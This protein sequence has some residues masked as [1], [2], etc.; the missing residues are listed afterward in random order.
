MRSL[1]ASFNCAEDGI[2]IHNSQDHL[3][4]CT[5]IKDFNEKANRLLLFLSKLRHD[6][7]NYF[8]EK[9]PHCKWKFVVG[10]LHYY[11]TVYL[12]CIFSYIWISHCWILVC[13]FLVTEN[14]CLAHCLRGTL[15]KAYFKVLYKKASKVKITKKMHRLFSFVYSPLVRRNEFKLWG[16]ESR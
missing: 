8:F 15:S 14:W 3:Y 7:H 10:F 11:D 1:L 2:L 6:Q 4:S 9:Q 5:S 13:S 16:C 12:F